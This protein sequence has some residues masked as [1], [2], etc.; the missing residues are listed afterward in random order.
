MKKTLLLLALFVVSFLN[1]FAQN[2]VEDFVLNSPEQKIASKYS[3][4]VVIDSR[5][6]TTNMG[7]I[8]KG[9]FNRKAFLKP[10]VDLNTQIEKVFNDLI[11]DKM[12]SGELVLNIRDFKFAEVTEAFSETGYCYFRADLFAKKD[13]VTYQKIDFIDRVFDVNAMDVTKKNIKNGSQKLIE[14]ISKNLASNAFGDEYT[15]NDIKNITSLEKRK[16]PIYNAPTFTNGAYMQFDNFKRNEPNLI[17]LALTKNKKGKITKVEWVR[18]DGTKRPID[19][20]GIY[21]LVDEGKVYIAN[22]GNLIPV[23]FKDDDFYYTGRAKVTAS[24][25]NVILASAFFGIFGA[26]IASDA[27]AEFKMKIDHLNGATIQV[28]QIGK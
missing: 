21:A 13:S 6:D 8:Q 15:L 25:G 16:I 10:T 2:L 14:F 5:M 1:V 3:K 19:F 18:T 9:A 12:G 20:E 11:L 28:Q 26:L 7:I 23:E 22:N 27:S 17:D 4:I 24:T